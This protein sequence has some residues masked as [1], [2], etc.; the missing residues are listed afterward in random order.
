MGDWGWV[1]FG[2][3]ITWGALATYVAMLARRR[4]RG[5]GTR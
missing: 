2:H 1:L 3:G 4:R 5:G